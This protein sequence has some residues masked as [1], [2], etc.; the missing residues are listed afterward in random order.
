[1][2]CL[3][4]PDGTV[5]RIPPMDREKLAEMFGE[6]FQIFKIEKGRGT[7]RIIVSSIFRMEDGINLLASLLASRPEAFFVSGPAVMV[8]PWEAK[9]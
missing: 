6:D 9:R 5:E 7:Y 1:M 4:R 3:L 2:A 8:P